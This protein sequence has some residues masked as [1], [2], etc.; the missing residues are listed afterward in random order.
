MATGKYLLVQDTDPGYDP[1][2]YNIV[3]IPL[4]QARQMWYTG[5]DLRAD[6]RTASCSSGI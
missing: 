1:A 6:I 5:L 3:I 2:G 4:Y